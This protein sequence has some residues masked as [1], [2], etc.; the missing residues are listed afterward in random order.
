[1]DHLLTS[2]VLEQTENLFD[3][4]Q[5][6][7]RRKYN[8]DFPILLLD[9]VKL[10]KSHYISDRVTQ[11]VLDQ[12]F[13]YIDCQIFNLFLRQPQLFTASRGFKIKMAISQIESSLSKHSATFANKQFNY[14]KEAANLLVMDKS[15]MSDTSLIQQIF[16]HLNFLQVKHIVERFKPDELSPDKTPE[17]VK[18]TLRDLC[19]QKENSKLSLDLDPMAIKPINL[20][21]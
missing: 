15:L 17:N 3:N 5:L 21:L 19:L 20:L 11:A 1:M 9:V 4:S 10:L 16:S 6:R 8:N 7:N 13:Y 18:Q 2:Y 14:I 12:I